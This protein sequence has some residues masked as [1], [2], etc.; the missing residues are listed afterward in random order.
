MSYTFKIN[1]NENQYNGKLVYHWCIFSCCHC[2]RFQSYS[3]LLSL[4]ET[5]YLDTRIC[6]YKAN[7]V[8]T[9]IGATIL[10]LGDS[11]IVHTQCMGYT[12]MSQNE[13]TSSS[14]VYELKWEDVHE[15]MVGYLHYLYLTKVFINVTFL[16]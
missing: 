8:N 6:F 2:P 5:G 13:C 11:T 10:S 3:V 15:C 9:L 4:I 16:D 1:S 7:C 12:T 14:Q